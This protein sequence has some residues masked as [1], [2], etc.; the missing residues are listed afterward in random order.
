MALFCF[1]WVPL[2]YLFW[3]CIT[4]GSNTGWVWALIAGFISALLQFLLGPLVDPVGFGFSRWASGFVDIVA[5]PVLVPLLLYLLLFVLKVVPAVD[6]FANFALIWLIP[7]AGARSLTWGALQHD[8]IVLVLVPILW[9]AIAVGIPFFIN[10]FQSGRPPAILALFCMAI[11]AVPIAATTAYW[12]FFSQRT[13]MG[14]I[15]FL[16]AAAPMTI[17]ASLSFFRGDGE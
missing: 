2:F 1:L 6:G 12:A 8:S 15:F 7:T 3:R 9:T 13:V 10:L 11:L 5:L 14:V 16:V 4:T 17:S